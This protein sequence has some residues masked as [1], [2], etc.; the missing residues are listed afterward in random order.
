VEGSGNG[1]ERSAA[2][3]TRALKKIAEAAFA[4]GW[5]A[6]DTAIGSSFRGPRSRVARAKFHIRRV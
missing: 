1:S 3:A 4:G 5:E 2:G 6:V